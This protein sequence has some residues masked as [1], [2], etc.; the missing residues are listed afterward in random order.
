M[1]MNIPALRIVRKVV[2]ASGH[3]HAANGQFGSG[4]SSAA[5]K[6][7]PGKT[8]EKAPP[9]HNRG[10]LTSAE[11]KTHEKHTK[12]KL[13]GASQ[14][15]IKRFVR[16]KEA[17]MK[18]VD[19]TFLAKPGGPAEYQ[20]MHIEYGTAISLLKSLDYSEIHTPRLGGSTK[21]K[22]DKE[23]QDEGEKELEKEGS[24]L[25]FVKEKL[26]EESGGVEALSQALESI[27]DPKLKEII[28]AIH[29]DE[30]RHQAALEQWMAEN[31]GGEGEEDEPGEED[32][33]DKDANGMA[34]AALD[35]IR[36]ILEANGVGDED[37]AKA[38][39][40]DPDE[41]DTDEEDTEKSDDGDEDDKPD[42]L[43]EDDEEEEGDGK[44]T[45]KSFR[46][47]IIK[48]DQQICYGI[49]SEPDVVDLQG[50]RLSKSEIRV[51]CHKFM[52][53]SQ[54]INKEHNGPAKADIIESYIAPTDFTC[55]GQ[56]VRKGSWIMGVKVHDPEIWRAI[57]KGEI[58]GFSIAGNG[59]RTEIA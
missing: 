49:V 15:D 46:V 7:A 23:L 45:K 38:D 44:I 43:K 19:R 8:K 28:S 29:Q 1:I 57:K 12:Q 31:G 34:E 56:K 58:T 30:Q 25:D 33:L 17:Q 24:D 5:K 13:K 41:E 47:P 59:T 2:D 51:A 20:R 16:A 53:K 40:P 36:D 3:E 55:N 11:Y 39:D 35:Q 52:M 18:A 42:F 4:G 10:G 54:R 6:P 48:G 27:Q 14:E 37:T 22:D 32:E 50:D 26:Q 9:K 21:M